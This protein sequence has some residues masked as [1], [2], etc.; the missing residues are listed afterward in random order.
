MPSQGTPV[1]RRV[2]T[3]V[4]RNIAPVIHLRALAPPEQAL[5][6]RDDSQLIGQFDLAEQIIHAGAAQQYRVAE[7]PLERSGGVVVDGHGRRDLVKS[8]SAAGRKRQ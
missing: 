3:S 2:P 5:G 7:I 4:E 6:I 1:T 8:C